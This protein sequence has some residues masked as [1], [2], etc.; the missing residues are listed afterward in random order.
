[1]S[2]ATRTARDPSPGNLSLLDDVPYEPSVAA[3]V[4][5]ALEDL[6][7]SVSARDLAIL[8]EL[9]R[10]SRHGPEA[11]PVD[12]LF[13][14]TAAKHQIPVAA[15]LLEWSRERPGP[16]L[17]SLTA[18]LA[19][20]ALGPEG[21]DSRQRNRIRELGPIV[22]NAIEKPNAPITPDDQRLVQ[23]VAN[24]ATL[25]LRG[26][27]LNAELAERVRRAGRAFADD[28]ACFVQNRD[29]RLRTPTIDAHVVLRESVLAASLCAIGSGH[30]RKFVALILR[31]T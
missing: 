18:V 31:D 12:P 24:G 27:A 21:R 23:D 15:A 28:V 13:L 2:A 11:E 20:L 10:Y 17:T 7:S 5:R 8:G 16:A 19:N 22:R 3:A 29:V 4:Q 1:M 6:A 14:V 9:R 26:V 30:K 25:L